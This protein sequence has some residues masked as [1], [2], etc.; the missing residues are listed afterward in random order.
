M[1]KKY[2]LMENVKRYK[3]GKGSKDKREIKAISFLIC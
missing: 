2:K 3:E 1:S